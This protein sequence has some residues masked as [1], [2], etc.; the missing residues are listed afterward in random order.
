[1]PPP[2]LCALTLL[3]HSQ[4]K[5]KVFSRSWTEMAKVS[6]MALPDETGNAGGFHSW[7]TQ[8]VTSIGSDSSKVWRERECEE[9]VRYPLKNWSARRMMGSSRSSF[10][11]PFAESAWLLLPFKVSTQVHSCH[12]CRGPSGPLDGWHQSPRRGGAARCDGQCW[13]DP[14][15]CQ[16]IGWGSAAPMSRVWRQSESGSPCDKERRRMTGSSG[17]PPCPLQSRSAWLPFKMSTE[18][19]IHKWHTER[20]NPPSQQLVVV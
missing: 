19:V 5:E 9:S 4:A 14:T 16:S 2:F 15:I 18:V 10:V 20:Q 17:T 13:L 3:F 11:P 8:I 12:P 7:H 6:Q 1:M